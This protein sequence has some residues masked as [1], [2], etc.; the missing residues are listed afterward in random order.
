MHSFKYILSR[1]KSL[2]RKINFPVSALNFYFLI[3]LEKISSGGSEF[4]VS[5]SS[6]SDTT[7]HVGATSTSET[8][9]LTF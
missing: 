9:K 5:P 2:K 7:L 8:G 1:L 3:T 4:K 6:V